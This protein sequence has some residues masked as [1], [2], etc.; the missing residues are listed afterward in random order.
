MQVDEELAI[1][2]PM[3]YP[4]SPVDRQ[5]RLANTGCAGDRRTAVVA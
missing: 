5:R 3:L 1:R 4:M 2:I